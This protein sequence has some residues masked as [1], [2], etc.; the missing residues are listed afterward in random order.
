LLEDL[1]AKHF[2][3]RQALMLRRRQ[4]GTIVIPFDD[5]RSKSNS[6][7]VTGDHT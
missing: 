6:R 2:E 4:V 1:P 3:T 7:D 5:G